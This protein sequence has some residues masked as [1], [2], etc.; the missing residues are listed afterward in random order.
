[1]SLFP[2]E[3]YKV[4]G[5]ADDV[6]RKMIDFQG[7]HYVGSGI[8]A[9]VYVNKRSKIAYKMGTVTA[10]GGYISYVRTL[11][12]QKQQNPFTPKIYGM[13]YLR[14]WY[15]SEVFVVAMEALEELDY[16]K[17]T[18]ATLLGRYLE[19]GE[20][21]VFGDFAGMGMSVNLS[22]ELVQA[23]EILHEAYSLGD[24]GWDLHDG[25]FMMR[26]NQMVVT[27]PFV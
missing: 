16:R 8:C 20:S 7:A 12:N 26:G 6:A 22:P 24:A 15:D 3:Q 4:D 17:S 27:D 18:M 14:G 19:Y 25:N 10:N 23:R 2:V 9:R 11:A 5:D 21:H 13:R 1:M